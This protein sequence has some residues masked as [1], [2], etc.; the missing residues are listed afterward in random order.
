MSKV[1]ENFGKYILL[2]RLAAGGMAE[3]YLAKSLGASGISKNIAIKR[4]L[5]QYSENPEFI[6]M[7]KE[8]AKIAVNLNH[9]NVV[10]I[11]DFG[12]EKKQFFLVMEFVDGQN[13]RQVLNHLK[14][15]SKQ[16]TLDQIVYIIKEVAAGL[17][18]AHRCID[19]TTGRPLNITH[20]DMSPQNIMLSFGGEVK[21]VDFGIAKAE[22]QLEHTRTGT[23]KGKF[24]YMSPEQ[25]EGNPVDKRTDIFSLGIV[26]WELLANDR[27]FTASSE[28]AT[29]KK[30]RECQI[31]SLRKLN[32]AIP[33]ELER[34]SNKALTKDK[35]LRYQEASDLHRDLNRFLNTQYPEFT[36]HE[37]SKFMKSSFSLMFHENRKKLVEYAK[38]Q[39][40]D[41]EGNTNVTATGTMTLTDEHR[42]G[43]HISQ[44]SQVNQATQ[45]SRMIASEIPDSAIP[46]DL[47]TSRVNLNDFKVKSR[48]PVISSPINPNS[49]VFELPQHGTQTG[50]RR[51][52]SRGGTQTGIRPAPPIAAESSNRFLYILGSIFLAGLAFWYWQ[53][54]EKFNE[55]MNGHF[56][57]AKIADFFFPDGKSKTNSGLAVPGQLDSSSTVTKQ[58]YS[59]I[60]ESFPPG[61]HLSIDGKDT[62][63]ITP[64]RRIV[65]A[66]KEFTVSLRMEGYQPYE[67]KEFATTNGY[68]IR[69]SL[70]PLPKMGYINLTVVNG[71]GN[72]VVLINGT[73]VEEK[74]PLRNYGVLANSKIRIQAH[75]PFSGLSA[76]QT[77]TVGPNQRRQVNLIL[78]QRQSH[79]QNR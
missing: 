15:D 33:P 60:I 58:P 1:L 18:H 23:I 41:L 42:Q 26:L 13:L 21:V 20:R 53:N 38:V 28:A 9:G 14:K 68:Q 65:D 71:G 76:E 59:V 19:A 77:V 30:I 25:A 74:L 34:I 4:I 48:S 62:G 78:G 69:A 44:I 67:R 39:S 35:N 72:L 75:N 46:I 57:E 64:A 6:E 22:T 79:N 5:P 52:P 8:E 32:P 56:N 40:G 47:T 36:P 29:L 63:M 43:S 70:L 66:D 24:G 27:L 61:A 45:G 73:R 16:F 11:F 54:K 17:D 31:P 50:I 2:E 10:S 49:Q 7:F 12:V 55:Q 37:F 3:V 51:S